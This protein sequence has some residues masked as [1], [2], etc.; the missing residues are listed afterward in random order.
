[1]EII[2]QKA[3]L[4]SQ[5]FM[6]S[7][8]PGSAAAIGFLRGRCYYQN[9]SFSLSGQNPNTVVARTVV[10]LLMY[11]INVSP[12]YTQGPFPG[13]SSSGFHLYVVR[14]SPHAGAEHLQRSDPQGCES[15]PRKKSIIQNNSLP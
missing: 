3:L 13:K 10:S 11:G 7:C 2:E 1:M 6:F 14:R 9:Q 5:F 15:Q 12:R 4:F 8:L